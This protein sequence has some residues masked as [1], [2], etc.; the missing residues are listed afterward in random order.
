MTPQ[1]P[2]EHFYSWAV[3]G[4]SW[5]ATF[6]NTRAHVSGIRSDADTIAIIDNRALFEAGAEIYNSGQ[7]VILTEGLFEG[8]GWNK[9]CIGIPPRFIIEFRDVATGEKVVDYS[10]SSL[11][12][13]STCVASC[14]VTQAEA[15]AIMGRLPASVGDLMLQG[16]EPS[17][18]APV[19]VRDAAKT[20]EAKVAGALVQPKSYAQERFELAG[21]WPA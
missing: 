21:R 4:W 16:V 20:I 15:D 18:S 2:Q 5:R 7:S 14:T 11:P 3:A 9:R 19:S 17:T 10:S 6:S 1:K 12:S 13:S 8:Q